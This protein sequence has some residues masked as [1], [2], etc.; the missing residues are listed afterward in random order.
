VRTFTAAESALIPPASP[1]ALATPPPLVPGADV[2]GAGPALCAVALGCGLQVNFGQYH[3]IA[4][5]WLSL[6]LAGCVLCVA[7]PGWSLFRFLESRATLVVALALVTQF[8]LLLIRSP[9]ATGRLGDG[10]SLLPFRVGVVVAGVVCA[11]GMWGGRRW[12]V[13]SLVALLL[14]FALLGS[15]VLR[16]APDPGVDVCL[17]QRDASAALLQGHNP[18]AISFPDPYKDSSRFYGPGV[19]TDGRLRFGYPYPPLSLLL[20]APAHALGDFRYAHL[21]AMTLAGALIA[22]ARPGR[23]AFAAAALLLFTPRGF[24]VLEAGWTEPLAVLFLSATVFVACRSQRS[25]PVA[26]G[27]LIA[28]KQYLVLAVL[29]APLLPRSSRGRWTG[30]LWKAAIVIAAITLPLALWDLPAFVHSTVLLQFRQPF[31]DDA[32]S[33]LVPL[34]RLLGTPPPAW[35]PFALAAAAA[36]IAAGRSPRTPSGFALALALVLLVFFAFNK[37]AFCN[38][39]HTVIGALCCAAGAARF[40]ADNTAT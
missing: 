31:R 7:K 34:A 24:F 21:A 25:I 30:T 26:L 1:A 39:Y 10:S 17:F 15:W 18:Y 38:Y 11:A 2:A 27:A 22:L 9:G 40:P 12:H 5:V 33:Y 6:A 35:I 28:V 4:L 36:I 16:A 13:P 14:T 19:S 23:L 3:P 32:L 20:V 37:Q 8:T 29:V